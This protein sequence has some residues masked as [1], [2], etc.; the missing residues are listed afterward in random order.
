MPAGRDSRG[1]AEP[2]VSVVMAARNEAVF[3]AGAL[4][5][6]LQQTL[7]AI[8]VIVVDDRSTDETPAILRG[9]AQRDSRV[10][11][12]DC[13]SQGLAA[14]LNCGAA[15]A[16]APFLA[17]MDADDLAEPSG[18]NRQ[19]SFLE[20]HGSVGAVGGAIEL[21]DALGHRIGRVRFPTRSRAI[22]KTLR[23]RNCLA[24]SAVMMRTAAF[25][26]AGG[27][28]QAFFG[29][30]DYDLWLRLAETHDLANLDDVVTR[31]RIHLSQ[32]TTAALQS[33]A[34][35]AIAARLCERRRASGRPEPSLP[36]SGF[37]REWVEE[38]GV[39]GP[40]LAAALA[41]HCLA[42]VETLGRSPLVS[43]EDL[44]LLLKSGLA[45][46]GVDGR[47]Q[48][49]AGAEWLRAKRHLRSGGL[50]QAATALARSVRIAPFFLVGRLLDRLATQ[51]R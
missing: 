46:I 5:S 8:E 6:V 36:E 22:R 31:H 23:I 25:R 27:Y 17:R 16:R 4:N 29:C 42:R 26:Q 35:G 30:E 41:R 20:R 49:D 2:S 40:A 24:H 45:W 19:L 44:D 39:E 15:A 33:Q 51:Y 43:D 10:R 48:L 38:A 32:F 3:V 14:A 50:N 9:I 37:T 18:M 34:L 21:I 12:I 28:R 13:A 11:I 47:P 7:E 1:H